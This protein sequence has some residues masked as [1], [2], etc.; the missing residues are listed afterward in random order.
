MTGPVGIVAGRGQLPKRLAARLVETG[1][2]GVV[3]AL[4]GTGTDGFAGLPVIA[5]RYEKLGRLFADLR[6]HAVTRIVLAGAI[7]RPEL[8]LRALDL[9]TLRAA[10]RL[11]RAF[12]RGDDGLL[13][14]VIGLFEKAGFAVVGAH[15]FLPDLTLPPGAAGRHRPAPADLA[16]IARADE[17]LGA[18]G[19]VDLGQA[20]VVAGGLCLGLET[21]QGTD[22]LLGFV[23]ETG[24]RY[25][26]GAR[27]VLVKRPKQ[28]QDPRVDMPVIGPGTVAASAR[29]GL[30]GIAVAADAV[31]VVDAAETIAAAD[32]AGLFLWAMAGS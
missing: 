7:E 29:A 24:E 8:D 13:R 1:Q 18:L 14:V 5:A 4:P 19:P 22:A 2:T 6:G 28:A 9:T 21:I 16:D 15:A 3:A 17:I 30:A 12:R 10:P 27:G 11:L 25:R 20:A 26:R 31:M 23:A 32:A